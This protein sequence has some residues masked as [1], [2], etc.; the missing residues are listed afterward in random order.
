MNAEK[1]HSFCTEDGDCLLWQRSTDMSGLPKFTVKREGIART[2]QPRR[3]VYEATKG[4][5]LGKL[6]V[7]AKCGNPLCLNPEHLALITPGKV[8]SNTAKRP[9]VARRR[10]LAGLVCRE[11]SVLDMDKVREIRASSESTSEIAE[12]YGVGKTTVTDIR[13]NRRWRDYS[14]PFAGLM[15]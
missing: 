2:I 1:L 10:H 14:N 13:K 12:R 6:R 9:D 7:T 3:V 11:R 15:A 8:V 4:P 5:I